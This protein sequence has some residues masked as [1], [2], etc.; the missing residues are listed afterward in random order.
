ML[1]AASFGLLFLSALF[2][3]TSRQCL[4][5]DRSSQQKL[6]FCLQVYPQSPLT[7]ARQLSSSCQRAKGRRRVK[8][9]GTKFSKG[10]TSFFCSPAAALVPVLHPLVAMSRARR[11][12]IRPNVKHTRFGPL[13]CLV[14]IQE[15]K[16]LNATPTLSRSTFSDMAFYSLNLHHFASCITASLNAAIASSPRMSP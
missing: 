8:P 6:R 4:H 13:P 14:S 10:K 16:P 3:L 15:R 2:S 1:M 9:T 12:N 7:H 11:A 5:Q